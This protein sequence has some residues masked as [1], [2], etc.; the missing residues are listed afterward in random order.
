[1]SNE[2]KNPTRSTGNASSSS[3]LRK[4][5]ERKQVSSLSKPR[6][7]DSSP[8]SS[9]QAKQQGVLLIPITRKGRITDTSVAKAASYA[10]VS[11]QLK[12]EMGSTG[13][14]M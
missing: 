10:V 3:K 1:M 2:I 9:F 4:K 12:M 14:D 5:R 13:I 8:D 7:L 11:R 6:D